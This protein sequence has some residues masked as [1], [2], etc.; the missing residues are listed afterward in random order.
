LNEGEALLAAGCV[1]HNYLLFYPDAMEASLIAGDWDGIE[2]YAAALEAYTRP[3]P[4]PWADLRIA[5]G[6]ALARYGRG[7]R[8]ELTLR[9]LRRLREEADRIGWK[10]ALPALE[11]ALIAAEA[12]GGAPPTTQP[13]VAGPAAR[14]SG[15]Q[16]L[17]HAKR[18]PDSPRA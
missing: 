15:Y 12:F 1:S 8:G 4:L 3:E 17:S 16:R 10:T 6:R 11:R 2:R 14:P 13:G 7:E 9:E 5:R 18:I